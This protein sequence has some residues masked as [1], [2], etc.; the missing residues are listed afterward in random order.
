MSFWKTDLGRDIFETKYAGCFSGDPESFYDSMAD[1]FSYGNRELAARFKD[2]LVTG[3]FTPG[4]RIMAYIG[5]PEAKVSLMNCTTHEVEGDTLEAIADTAHFLMRASS[6]GQGIGMNLSKLR[7]KGSAV[8]NAAKTSTGAISFMEM[9]DKVGGT[10]GQEGRRGAM[11]FSMRVDHPDMWRPGSKDVLCPKC[12]GKG[13]MLCKGEGYLQYR[14]PHRQAHP[15]QGG[16]CQYL[17]AHHGRF[18]AGCRA[19]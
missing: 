18:Y 9:L 14:L 5:R 12:G 8:D 13:C 2:M 19:G 16:K 4:G 15:R 3:K 11:L 17:R 10:I 1:T 6:R 7:P